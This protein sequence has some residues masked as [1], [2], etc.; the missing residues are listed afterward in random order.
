MSG[1]QQLSE[2]QLA[3][4]RALWDLGEGTTRDVQEA[5][6]AL[7]R[8]LAPTTV[9]TVLAR[10]EKRGLVTHR[11]D[12]R[13]YIYRATVSRQEMQRSVISRVTDTLFRGDVTALFS[14]LLST[15]DI[16]P[17][18]LARVKALIEAR[19]READDDPDDE[20]GARE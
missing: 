7:G 18:D 10:L 5:L 3:F 15:R 19:E 1:S 14:Q 13:Q 4:M 12:G 17:G 2:V 9:T 11:R 16:G 8:A 6:E 20:P